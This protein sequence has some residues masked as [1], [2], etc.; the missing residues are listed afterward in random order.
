MIS[1]DLEP[2]LNRFLGFL[3]HVKLSLFMI[4]RSVRIGWNELCF[5]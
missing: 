1:N 3:V 5:L 4:E 2:F